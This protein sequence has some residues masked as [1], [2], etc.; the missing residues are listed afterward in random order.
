MVFKCFVRHN[1]ISNIINLLLKNWDTSP[2][3]PFYLTIDR[4]G[5]TEACVELI[6]ILL[7]RG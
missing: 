3:T 4:A 5:L 1:F 7:L 2:P 6:S